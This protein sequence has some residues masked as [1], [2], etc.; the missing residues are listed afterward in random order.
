MACRAQG[1][2]FAYTPLIDVGAL[3]HG[4]RENEF[5]LMRGASEPW[6]GVQLLGS[7]PDDIAVS[8]NIL[9]RMNFDSVDFNMG[10][11]MQKVLKRPAG[12]ALL[13]PEN[14]EL[15]FRCVKLIRRLTK[16]PFTV[17]MRILDFDEPEPTVTFCRHLEELGVEGITIHGRL[18]PKIYS[19]P[20]ATGVIRAVREV[21]H[22]P[23]TANGGVYKMADAD[24]LADATGCSRIMLA[25]GTL[26]NPWLFRELLQRKHLPPTNDELCDAILAHVNG[27]IDIYGEHDACILARKITIAYV[28]GRGYRKEYRERCTL[29]AD[30]TQLERMVSDMR[31]EGPVSPTD[32]LAFDN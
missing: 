4:N 9:E 3:A 28:R 24:A 16:R 31:R 7:I 12:A 2:F 30:K 19:G 6:L 22:I 15:A 32:A 1:A 13:R 5:I 8:M 26:G 29:L 17:K 14:Q 20:V 27:M 21:L 23:V 11:P 18:T 25:R 10:C